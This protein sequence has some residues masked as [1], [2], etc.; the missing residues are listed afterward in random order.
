MRGRVIGVDTD[1]LVRWLVADDADQYALAASVI[2][3][4]ATD[5]IY[6]SLIVLIELTWVLTRTYK[7]PREDVLAMV[8]NLLD[9]RE[10]VLP[11]RGLALEAVGFSR[12]H[13][14]EFADALLGVLN[15]DAGCSTTATFDRRAS[16]LSVMTLLDTNFS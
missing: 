7:Y 8:E 6:I 12:E 9:M 4:A 14:C 1:V 3:E 11:D 2:S 16:R 5:E 15:R 13:G 10:I